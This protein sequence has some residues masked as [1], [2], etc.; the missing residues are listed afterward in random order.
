MKNNNPKPSTN[1]QSSSFHHFISLYGIVSSDSSDPL[2]WVRA[3]LASKRGTLMELG[4]TPIVTTG[5]LFQI[6][7]GAHILDVNFDLKSDRELFQ[8]AQKRMSKKI[9]LCLALSSYLETNPFP[10]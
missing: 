1:I 4:I 6:F 7:G 2:Y 9:L 3:I 5:L 10:L 8:S